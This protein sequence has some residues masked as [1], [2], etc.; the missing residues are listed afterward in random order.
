MRVVLSEMIT[1]L[2]GDQ[3]R[4]EI[5]VGDAT[6]ASSEDKVDLLALSCFRNSYIPTLGTIVRAL[7]DRGIEVG[8][9][10]ST[11]A[12]DYRDKWHT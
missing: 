8:T 6:A 7:W 9:W 2:G 3:R 11:P 5:C 12:R 10:A 1:S 4:L